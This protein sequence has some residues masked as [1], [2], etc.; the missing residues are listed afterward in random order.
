MKLE[1]YAVLSNDDN[2][3]EEKAPWDDIK[4]KKHQKGILDNVIIN[5]FLFFYSV[6]YDQ[7]VQ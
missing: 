3:G 4:K 7:K 6:L 5:H 2:D 1:E